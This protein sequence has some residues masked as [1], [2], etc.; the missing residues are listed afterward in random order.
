M[1]TKFSDKQLENLLPRH[2]IGTSIFELNEFLRKA[3]EIDEFKLINYKFQ[4]NRL[5]FNSDFYFMFQFD[6]EERYV[7]IGPTLLHIVKEIKDK[8]LKTN[9]AAIRTKTLLSELEDNVT[10][11]FTKFF[12]RTIN[13]TYDDYIKITKLLQDLKEQT[14]YRLKKDAKI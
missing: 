7:A 13:L 4:A 5:N 8:Y 1:D 12:N 14:E 3:T 10:N 2:F 6:D 9:A 11:E